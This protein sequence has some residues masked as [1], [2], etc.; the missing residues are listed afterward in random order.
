MATI[1]DY[2]RQYKDISFQ[3]CPFNEMDNLFFTQLSYFNWSSIVPN[4]HRKI[5]MIQAV[6]LLLKRIRRYGLFNEALFIR[7][8]LENLKIIKDGKRYQNCLLS[9]FVYEMNSEKQFGALCIHLNL[10]TL[11]VSFEGTDNSVGGWK[12][13][14][15]LSYKFPVQSQLDSIEYLKKVVRFY[16]RTVYVGGHSKGGNLAMVAAMY[17]SKRIQKRIKAQVLEKRNLSPIRL[18]QYY[19]S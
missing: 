12:E 15:E 6:N 14:F 16:H 10:T 9:D 2:L 1:K 19:L 11:Y 17:T 3:E 4:S 8:C 5:P 7:G 13:D 18:R